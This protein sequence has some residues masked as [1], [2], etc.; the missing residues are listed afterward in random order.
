[1]WFQR[2]RQLRA[3]GLAHVFQ[4]SERSPCRAGSLSQLALLLTPRSAFINKRVWKKTQRLAG[5]LLSAA[6]TLS[7]AKNTH[8]SLLSK[9]EQLL[10]TLSQTVTDDEVERQ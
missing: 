3:T 7:A 8:N 5:K 6:K 9:D 1:M 4:S 2:L 10:P